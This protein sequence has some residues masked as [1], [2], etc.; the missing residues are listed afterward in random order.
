MIQLTARYT[1]VLYNLLNNPQSKKAID[2]AMSE[3][4]MYEPENPQS[5]TIMP[6]REELNKRILD[7]YKYREI[8]FETVGRFID[9]LKI[10]LNE[11]MPYYYQLFKSQDVM[12]GVEDVFGNVDIIETFNES[13]S[14]NTSNTSEATSSATSNTSATN[15][16]KDVKSLTPQSQLSITN[17]NIDSVD[18]ADQV[19]WNK[20]DSTSNGSDNATTNTSGENSRVGSI[21][22]T[23]TRKGNQGVNTYA[24]DMKELR[25]SFLNI[26]DDII[27]HPRI[28]ELFLLIY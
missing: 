27:N 17:K 8:G 1:E 10:S 25:T 15:N 2:K 3:Y 19:E 9:E 11:I 21:E 24:H 20:V 16:S 13:S 4:P 18:Y 7:Y 12:N 6:T 28:S 5:Y 22:H 23:L 14:D 26:I